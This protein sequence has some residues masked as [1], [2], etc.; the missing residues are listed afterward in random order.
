MTKRHRTCAADQAEQSIDEDR[1]Q[2][3]VEDRDWRLD[4]EAPDQF[5]QL[6][7][8]PPDCTAER[9]SPD[10]PLRSRP[11]MLPDGGR[12]CRTGPRARVTP[13]RTSALG[14]RRSSLS[15]SSR[16]STA[17]WCQPC[18]KYRRDSSRWTAG[19]AGV[20]EQG[21]QARVQRGVEVS[22]CRVARRR[23]QPRGDGQALAALGDHALGRD[24]Q[25]LGAL[26]A[27]RAGDGCRQPLRF[28]LVFEL[29]QALGRA[30]PRPSRGP[31]RAGHR[32]CRPPPSGRWGRWRWPCR[33]PPRRPSSCPC[34]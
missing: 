28:G 14:S 29:G 10:W 17:R 4:F 31:S 6:V 19:R 8:H 7:K 23:R 13:P 16:W 11:S 18:M 1:R 34:G 9:A 20:G 22:G 15:S 26:G 3:N 24:E 2:R 21:A 27:A 5:Q 30:R 32:P 12:D 33:M 25:A